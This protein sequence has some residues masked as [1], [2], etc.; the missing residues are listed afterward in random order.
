MSL[1]TYRKPQ[2]ESAD[3]NDRSTRAARKILEKAAISEGIDDWKNGLKTKTEPTPKDQINKMIEDGEGT[4]I[5]AE[6][7][8]KAVQLIRY[9]SDLC[10][11]NNPLI[12]Q[13]D[14]DYDELSSAADSA[15]VTEVYSHGGGQIDTENLIPYSLPNEDLRADE[16][17]D[18]VYAFAKHAQEY[19]NRAESNYT[20]NSGNM[21][22]T[23]VELV[24][25]IYPDESPSVAL[26]W[27][28]QWTRG[29][30]VT[31]QINPDF[32]SSLKFNTGTGKK[33]KFLAIENL[34]SSE[35]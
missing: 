32:T 19:S 15:G 23:T 1:D 33:S 17:I 20:G 21:V 6:D 28:G 24:D 11:Q 10:V 12:Y 26:T 25:S 31:I 3:D 34:V 29:R 9:W 4:I 7:P 8:N 27:S 18:S 5:F 13:E 14:D 22:D 16:F 30:F 2:Y 35:K